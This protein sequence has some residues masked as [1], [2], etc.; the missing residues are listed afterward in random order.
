M[1]SVDLALNSRTASKAKAFSTLLKTFKHLDNLKNRSVYP[2][3][4]KHSQI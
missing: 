2:C 4:P 3:S 1:I